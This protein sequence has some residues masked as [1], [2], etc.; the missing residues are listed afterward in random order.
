MI[1]LLLELWG[2]VGVGLIGDNGFVFWCRNFFSCKFFKVVFFM[3]VDFF[4]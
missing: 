3:G 2:F 4:L 1:V